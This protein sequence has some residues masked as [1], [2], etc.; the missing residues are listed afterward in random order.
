VPY[1]LHPCDNDIKVFVNLDAPHMM[2]LIRNVLQAVGEIGS[3]EGIISFKYFVL[4]HE[5]QSLINLK[6]E[7]KVSNNHVIINEGNKMKV[8]T[9][10]CAAE[11]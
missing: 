3:P 4:L 8:C 2:K 6:L 5:F 10:F 9:L 7:N 1:F 11:L